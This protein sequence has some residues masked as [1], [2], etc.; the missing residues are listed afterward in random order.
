MVER[1]RE[2]LKGMT[3]AADCLIVSTSLDNPERPGVG[4]ALVMFAAELASAVRPD[5]YRGELPVGLVAARAGAVRAGG[6][7]GCCGSPCD[8]PPGWAQ[9]GMGSDGV[10]GLPDTA[11]R[12]AVMTSTPFLQAVSM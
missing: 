8:W 1:H 12:R 5:E 2:C 4:L 6:V 3:D 9:V 10:Q 7:A 11:P